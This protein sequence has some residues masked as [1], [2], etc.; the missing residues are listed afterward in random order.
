MVFRPRSLASASDA[1]VHLH[2]GPGV[3]IVERVAL[4]ST[5]FEGLRTRGVPGTVYLS[6]PPKH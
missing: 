3:S 1:V 6:E 2:G 4:T 5:F